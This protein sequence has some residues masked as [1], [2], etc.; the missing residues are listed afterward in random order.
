[1]AAITNPG[2]K[3][4]EFSGD[5]KMLSL[6]NLSISSASDALTLSYVD[7]G[8]SEIQNVVVCNN[9]GQ[10]AAFTAV[11][12]SFSDLVVTITSVEQDGTASTAWSD[13]T[14]NLIVIGK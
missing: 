7:N 2:T 3:V 12:A 14:V 10:D 6:Y 1:M 8:I 13:T 4:T 5:F 9:A 11:S